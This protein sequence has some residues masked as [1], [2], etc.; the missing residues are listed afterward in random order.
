[1][2]LREPDPSA[3]TTAVQ[4]MTQG[5]LSVGSD[6]NAGFG[7]PQTF[8][9][10]V[11]NLLARLEDEADPR[12]QRVRQSGARSGNEVNQDG[13]HGGGAL[14]DIADAIGNFFSGGPSH[15]DRCMAPSIEEALHVSVQECDAYGKRTVETT[16]HPSGHTGC[17]NNLVHPEPPPC[18]H[19]C[20]EGHALLWN[21]KHR[22]F[23]CQKC[24]AGTF[25]VGGGHIQ[26]RWPNGIPRQFETACFSLDPEKY[27]QGQQTW[28]EGRECAAWA[29]NAN[30]TALMSGNNS[31][32]NFI[33][34]YL[35]LHLRFVRPGSLWFR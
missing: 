23:N 22:R 14:G 32:Y 20:G 33:E 31:H 28:R 10:S 17:H 24:P 4:G 9:L 18:T 34:S 25:S 2:L 3:C 7:S 15:S 19:E 13:A 12:I 1:M 6:D 21:D 26:E 35:I 16:Y 29:V 11:D 5:E 27:A 8:A 30:G